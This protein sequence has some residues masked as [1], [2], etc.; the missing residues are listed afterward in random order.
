MK[1]KTLIS[2]NV[3]LL[4]L[5]LNLSVAGLNLIATSVS[6]APAQCFSDNGGVYQKLSSCPSGGGDRVVVTFYNATGA[7]IPAPA[8]NQCYESLSSGS[9]AQ[10]REGS[11][12]GY[13]AK[14]QNARRD[15]CTASGGSWDDQDQ[16]SALGCACPS[17]QSLS[18]STQQ[19]TSSNGAQNGTGGSSNLARAEG[20]N[21]ADCNNSAGNLD[22]DNC[23]IVRLLNTAF[24]LISGAVSLAVIGNIIYGGIQYS[25]AQGDP[26][27]AS[28][29]KTRIRN[30]VLAFLMYLSLYGFIQWLIPGGV[31]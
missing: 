17:G 30:A 14:L 23:G 6:A 10:Y 31:F 3:T 18:T 21:E 28:K 19:C 8:E 25:M 24:N 9:T 4:I 15:L 5:A 1:I 20:P 22:S 7:L 2:G 27:A 16:V 13:E 26:G 29:A 12:A 11:C